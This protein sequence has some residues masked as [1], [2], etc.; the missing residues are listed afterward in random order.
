M[1]FNQIKYDLACKN[2]KS[3]RL[4]G[5]TVLHSED[6][7]ENMTRDEL[8][9]EMDNF[10]NIECEN[11]RKKGD[12]LVLKIQI[13]QKN[14]VSNQIK[15]NIIKSNGNIRGGIESGFYSPIELELAFLKIREKIEEQRFRYFPI[16]ENGTAFILF[17]LLTIEPNGRVSIF[18]VEG[19]TL[20]E[21][22]KFIDELSGTTITKISK[23]LREK[24]EKA[25]D[26]LKNDIINPLIIG[27]LESIDKKE[28][29]YLIAKNPE[30][31]LYY[32][33]IENEF[34][35]EKKIAGIPYAN[36]QNME[37]IEKSIN[38][39]RARDFIENKNEFKRFFENDK[40]FQKHII[41]FHLSKNENYIIS[42]KNEIL[43]NLKFT[44]GMK[45]IPIIISLTKKV[46]KHEFV[47]DEI[48]FTYEEGFLGLNP[49]ISIVDLF[50]LLSKYCYKPQ[51]GNHLL[52][53]MQNSNNGQLLE[54]FQKIRENSAEENINELV[55]LLNKP[56]SNPNIQES[57]INIESMDKN[58]LVLNYGAYTNI[59]KKYI[60][61]DILAPYRRK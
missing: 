15:I 57:D 50:P 8:V 52:T 36:I 1:I 16:K 18:D 23:E 51:N 26:G 48:K 45:G 2:C 35:T 7:I 60:T 27:H 58:I 31:D 13:N 30:E 54:F 21:I 4:N 55:I 49:T 61:N 37:Y 40:I 53:L 41:F 10:V 34:I 5:L 17:D 19:I 38:P 12:W 29:I 9:M 6:D 11:C 44:L 43:K 20:E 25:F 32:G 24:L 28:N 56:E 42:V 14:E 59:F 22:S 33:I 47:D 3:I 39:F 46:I